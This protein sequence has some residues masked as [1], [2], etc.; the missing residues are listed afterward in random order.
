MLEMRWVKSQWDW[1]LGSTNV[2][3]Q[4]YQVPTQKIYQQ[5]LE[6][7]KIIMISS[8]RSSPY[9]PKQFDLSSHA[10]CRKIRQKLLFESSGKFNCYVL[11]LMEHY[12]LLPKFF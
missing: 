1:G 10:L 4:N 5:A 9:L 12:S 3:E 7:Q 6:P 2:L 11:L 8:P